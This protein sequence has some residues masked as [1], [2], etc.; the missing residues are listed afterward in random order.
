M[1][2]AT[3]KATLPTIA[4]VDESK[5]ELDNFYGDAFESGYFSEIELV[6]PEENLDQLIAKLLDLEVDALVS[7]FNLSDDRPTAYNGADVVEAFLAK[8]RN[9]PCFIRTSFDQDA[10]GSSSDVNRI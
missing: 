1:T 2:D 5:D 9:F 7:D 6:E 10:M 4:Y 3:G 8:R